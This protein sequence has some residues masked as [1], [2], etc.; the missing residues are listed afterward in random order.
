MQWP[1]S[2]PSETDFLSRNIYFGVDT[3]GTTTA[4]RRQRT[5]YCCNKGNSCLVDEGKSS[6]W[7]VSVITRQDLVSW[8]DVY[9]RQPLVCRAFTEASPSP[10]YY[11]CD[12]L[13]FLSWYAGFLPAAVISVLWYCSDFRSQPEG[14]TGVILIRAN[15][16]RRAHYG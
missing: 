16:Q 9:S 10:V 2:Q 15:T 4:C 13:D 1:R 11:P 14:F 12:K 8:N 6:S 3:N 5:L 7:S